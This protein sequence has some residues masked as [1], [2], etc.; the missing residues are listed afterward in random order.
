MQVTIR[1]RSVELT[2]KL[3]GHIRRRIAVALGRVDTDLRRVHVLVEDFNG[4]RGGVDKRCTVEVAGGPLGTQVFEERDVN[5]FAAVHRAFEKAR[6]AV[7][8]ASERWRDVDRRRDRTV[9]AGAATP[10]SATTT[11]ATRPAATTARSRR[12][13]VPTTTSKALGGAGDAG[14]TRSATS[15][16]ERPGSEAPESVNRIA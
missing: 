14:T 15:S 10:M 1:T 13:G 4:P 8:R 6:R 7:V 5:A 12:T 11:V 2:K 3:Q 16:I 9:T